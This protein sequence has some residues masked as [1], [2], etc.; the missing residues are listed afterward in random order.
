MIPPRVTVILIFWLKYLSHTV[1]ETI[2][3]KHFKY[4]TLK[5]FILF[6]ICLILFN[7]ISLYNNN[8]TIIIQ[9]YFQIKNLHLLCFS[10]IIMSRSLRGS[11]ILLAVCDVRSQ[12]VT[13][14]S[15]C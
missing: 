9:F 13:N 11:G 6:S 14:H 8:N 15:C 5:L 12:Q 7:H 1:T 4:L 2:R 10:E 3:K